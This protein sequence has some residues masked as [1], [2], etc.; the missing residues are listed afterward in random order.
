[1][2]ICEPLEDEAPKRRFV[3]PPQAEEDA[4]EFW[5]RP[6]QSAFASR[7][8]ELEELE[9]EELAA[10]AASEA[11]PPA[12]SPAPSPARPVASPADLYELMGGTGGPPAAPAAPA[13]P[14]P[15]WGVAE[16]VREHAPQPEQR[17]GPARVS[18]F[19]AERSQKG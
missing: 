12:T 15:K 8:R 5:Q 4:W 9:E 10:P 13:A 6:V 3:G 11:E 1:M 19:K 17:A 7:L 14:A 16:T 18:R 2:D